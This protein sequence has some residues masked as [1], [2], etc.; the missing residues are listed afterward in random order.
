M[1]DNILGRQSK[2]A[3]ELDNERAD[4]IWSPEETGT[5]DLYRISWSLVLRIKDD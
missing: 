2:P 1:E 5:Q 3:A 4:T